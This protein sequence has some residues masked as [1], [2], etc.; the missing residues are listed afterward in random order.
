MTPRIQKLILFVSMMLLV[1]VALFAQDSDAQED[2][3]SINLMELYTAGQIFSHL[4]AA[5]FVIVVVLTIVKVVELYG[6]EKID[7][8]KF[9]LKMKGHIRNE[10]YDE[11]IKIA[12]QFRGTTLGEMFWQSLSV[13]NDAR[14]AGKS[15]KELSD[16][17]QNAFDEAGMNM[18]P[19][20][21]SMLY[22]FDIVAQIATLMGLLG[23]IFG[24]IL[25]FQ[26]L[27]TIQDATEQQRRLT[28]GIYQAM[29]TTGLGLIV[30]IPTLAIKGFLQ[31]RAEKII[32]SIDEYAVKAINQINYS[33]KKD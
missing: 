18:V 21:N 7:H 29:G 6:K 1:N 8:K 11:A 13:F 32:A 30:A 20:I 33:L 27:A 22:W 10:N 25:A 26:A 24:L 14:K 23:T 31:G 2:Q 5:L 9:W 12:Q 19:K 28:T 3:Q 16:R 4:I 17:L 15:P